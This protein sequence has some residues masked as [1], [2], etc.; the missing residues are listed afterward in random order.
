MAA[1][2]DVLRGLGKW[3][4]AAEAGERRMEV[5]LFCGRVGVPA[6]TRVVELFVCA[7]GRYALWA[8]RG[9]EV[10]GRG[11]A[12]GDR[13]HRGVDQYSLEVEGEQVVELWAEVRWGA[14]MPEVG[15]AEMMGPRPLFW[16]AVVFVD[17]RGR[18]IGGTGTGT[19][20]GE[21]WR[22]A[23]CTGVEGIGVEGVS[24]FV[25]AGQGERQRSGGWPS[26]WRGRGEMEGRW[27]EPVVVG[28]VYFAGDPAMPGAAEVGPWLVEREIPQMEERAVV[29]RGVRAMTAGT[30]VEEEA[31][32]PLRAGA[33]ET[34]VVRA[35][36]GEEVLA[37]WRLRVSGKGT[38][39]RV[40]ASEVLRG[41]EVGG[42]RAF[43]LESDLPLVPFVDEYVVEGEGAS[44]F[45][46]WRWRA[47]RFLEIAVTGGEAG[48]VLESFTLSGTG[49]PFAAEYAFRA[50][51]DAGAVAE[52]I[53]DVSWRTLRCCAWETYMDCPGYEQLQYVGDARIQ[54]LVSYVTT[55]D[56]SLAAQAL[57]A[58]DRSRVVDGV[59]EL[60]QSRYPS[61]APQII[62]TFSLIYILM[63]EDYLA[64]TNDAGLVAQLRPGIAPIL[65]WFTE[66]IERDSAHAGVIG[67]LP[68]WPFVDWV[69]GW[70]K[71]IPPHTL[72]KE[73]FSGASA[74]VNL[75]YLLALQ[76][77]TEIYD[78]AKAGSGNF[79]ASR[80]AALKQRIYDV[81]FDGGR[82]L[83]CDI[84]VDEGRG[85]MGVWSQHAQ[86]LGVLAEVFSPTE[87]RR[88][89]MTV[90]EARNVLLP[91]EATHSPRGEGFVAP[92]SLY[93]SFYVAEAL[94]KLRMG[95]RVWGVLGPFRAA[96]ARGSTTW[97][98]S[99]AAEAA[100]S[101]CHAWGAWPLYFL[102]RHVLGIAAPSREDGRV[103]VRPLRV[104]EIE[105]AEGKFVTH[106]GA[107]SVRISW[108]GGKRVVEA[109]GAGVEVAGE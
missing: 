84:P 90:T 5:G 73:R 67:Y 58:F 50:E 31:V 3:V 71:G 66:H 85:R 95:E 102:G 29:V 38:R 30:L 42:K 74:C 109:G 59:G 19:G 33:G 68:Y 12:R 32:A 40:T 78:R 107:A 100:R 89:M 13:R 91:D 64:H 69:N 62:P 15:V 53:A 79:Y 99:F 27:A 103:R 18:V 70:D 34:V 77:A 52:K 60:T 43:S 14:G 63:L 45:D 16:A 1:W 98:E 37:Y 92:A 82:G 106:R 75:L 65:N 88:A 23:A 54:G 55:G 17:E 8:G 44:V 26:G 97:P 7:E 35:D 105:A 39:V 22:A 83:L 9:E 28:E 61:A 10:L 96:L 93:F 6:G 25:A 20:T 86:A 48:G 51:G 4:W 21:G 56:F 11:P 81:F 47:F 41:K 36:V 94:A 76:A 24:G 104:P 101:E 80:A 46:A 57:R 2:Y 108:A 49:Y 87:A 72:E